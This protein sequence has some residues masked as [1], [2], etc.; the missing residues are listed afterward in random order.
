MSE[1]SGV[2]TVNN[3]LLL[4]KKKKIDLKFYVRKI[5]YSQRL[6]SLKDQ[7]GLKFYVRK[8]W[9]FYSERLSFLKE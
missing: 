7:L 9:S 3:S 2:Y 6:S 1:K 8:I 5:L 4:G